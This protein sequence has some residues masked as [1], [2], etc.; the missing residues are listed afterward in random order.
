[1]FK[2]HSRARSALFAARANAGEGGKG[3]ALRDGISGKV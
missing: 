2:S 3:F 1:M